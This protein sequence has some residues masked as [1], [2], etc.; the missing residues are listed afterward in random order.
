[1]LLTILLLI[2]TIIPCYAGELPDTG[3]TQSYTTTFGEDHD[4][5]PAATQPS[6]TDNGNGTITDNRTTLMWVKDGNS[7]GCNNGA[8]LTWEQAL[9]FCEGLTYAGYSNWRLPNRREMFSIVAFNTSVPAI[10]TGYFLNTKLTYYWTSTTYIPITTN[11][12]YVDFSDGTAYGNLKT[13]PNYV[14]CVRAGP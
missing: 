2:G 5:Q 12:W 1:M 9:V 14:R 11:A 13:T 3:Q 6:Y 8:T 7:A 10:N 4:Y